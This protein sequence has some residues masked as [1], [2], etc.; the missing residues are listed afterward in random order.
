MPL[1]KTLIPGS[2]MSHGGDGGERAAADDFGRAA[3]KVAVSQLCESQGFHAVRT[4]ALD[5]LADVAI[6]YLVDLGKIAELYANL[7]GRSHCSVF[8]LIRGF[9]DL[10]AP[11]G[12][13]GGAGLKEIV[14]YVEAVDEVPFAQPIPQF[15]VIRER[16][17]IPSFDQMGETPPGK[18]I[19]A[20]L[21]ALPDPHTY[22]HTPVW[23]ERVSDP[24]EDKIEQARQRRKAERSLLSLQKRLLLCNGSAETTTTTNTAAATN[25]TPT[26]VAMDPGRADKD[27]SPVKIPAVSDGSRVSV[28]EAFAPAIEVLGSSSLCDDDGVE[29]RM[30]VPAARPTVHFKFRTGKKLIGESLDA[31]LQKKDAA[32][33]AA[34]LGGREDERDDKKR[35]AEY[36]LRQSIE[37]PQELT[38]L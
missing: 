31:R 25:A 32:S 3:A 38:L 27:V 35:R 1:H 13:S 4:S 33:R 11:R 34:S 17:S 7:S 37:N 19:P 22:I 24:R 5:S 28:L 10:E 18:H 9:E 21:P 8:D 36:I 16:R 12:F 2:N 30:V 15:P 20:W 29:G 14:N 26:G 23:D 6:R